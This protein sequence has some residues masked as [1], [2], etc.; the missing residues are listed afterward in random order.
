[1]NIVFFN[2]EKL[3]TVSKRAFLRQCI[4]IFLAII[5]LATFISYGSV[6]GFT[7]DSLRDYFGIKNIV[8]ELIVYLIVA[9]LISLH[10]WKKINKQDF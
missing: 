1:M 5:F 7:I 9:V 10:L 6:K 3:K 8:L 2:K 4:P